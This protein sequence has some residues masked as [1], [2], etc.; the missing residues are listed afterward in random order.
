MSFT[1]RISHS[2]EKSI[3]LAIILQVVL[4]VFTLLLLDGGRS[5]QIL[6]V[7]V[8][9]HWL[10]TVIIVCRRPLTPTKL[11]TMIVSSFCLA[12]FIAVQI[13]LPVFSQ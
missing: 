4:G 2:Y 13:A 6:G 3:R 7:A 11:D 9:S 8:L 1:V 12:A 5:S 10:L